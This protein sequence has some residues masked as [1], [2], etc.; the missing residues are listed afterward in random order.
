MVVL[1][2]GVAAVI[3]AAGVYAASSGLWTRLFASPHATVTV[4]SSPAGGIVRVNGVERGRTPL[5]V[6]VPADQLLQLSV[7]GVAGF[8]PRHETVVLGA[9]EARTITLSMVPQLGTR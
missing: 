9:G 4:L 7:V 1:A 6:D 5:T 3:G 2:L 8:H